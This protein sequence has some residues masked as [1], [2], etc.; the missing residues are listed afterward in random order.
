MHFPP[1][2]R[3][4]HLTAL[5]C[6]AFGVMRLPAQLAGPPLH[7]TESL[8][9]DGT[10][11][12][13]VPISQIAVARD[14][15]MAVW[16]MQDFKVLLFTAEGRPIG[17]FGKGGEGPGEF[18]VVGASGWVGDTLWILD[19]RLHRTTLLTPRGELV[20]TWTWPPSL[21]LPGPNP[22]NLPD[23]LGGIAPGAIFSDGSFVPLPGIRL[24]ARR[25]APSTTTPSDSEN[26]VRVSA[27]GELKGV[28]A[29]IPV[30]RTPA[31]CV[32]SWQAGAVSGAIAAPF[33]AA[34]TKAFSPDGARILFVRQRNETGKTGTFNLLVLSTRGETLLHRDI[35]YVPQRI[36]DSAWKA[37]E[38]GRLFDPRLGP[39][40]KA[41]RDARKRVER[42]ATY[43]PV[44]RAI[45]GRDGSI[46]LELFGESPGHRWATIDPKD[47]HVIG[48]LDVPAN[49][50]IRTV[51]RDMLWASSVDE[52]DVPSVVVLK[53]S[54]G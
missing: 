13:F 51:A 2:P 12:S 4:H 16:Q 20:R 32:Q 54:G 26:V 3:T 37:E 25:A 31:T 18:R 39:P 40:P 10:Q 1:I 27:R 49:V 34:P 21:Y 22:Q 28:L 47:G 45:L 50:T 30:L 35:A 11:H 6:I 7:Y 53:V 14:G 24:P 42:L 48:V 46:W 19:A 44:R 33:C 8:R 15:T 41:Y 29:R 52:D 5:C 43:P 23:A 9:L 38:A 36:S 17:S